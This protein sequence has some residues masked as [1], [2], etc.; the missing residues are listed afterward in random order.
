MRISKSEIIKIISAIR[1]NNPEAF[2]IQNETDFDTLVDLWY[3]M[4]QEYSQDVVWIAVK[5]ALKNTVYQRQ[6]W[7]GAICQEIDK[8]QIAYET[9]DLAL[10]AELTKVFSE[11][12]YCVSLTKYTFVE[13]NGLTQGENAQ[14]RIKEIFDNLSQEIKDYC[15]DISGLIKIAY[16]DNKQLSIEKGRFLQMMPK[17]KQQ[18]KTRKEIAD[19]VA[20]IMQNSIQLL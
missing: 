2:K 3:D 18:S 10:W 11:V 17:I 13:P 15:R 4:F 5:N 8:M 20:K 6:N 14:N 16:L 7:L 19:N 1:I 9:P 12:N